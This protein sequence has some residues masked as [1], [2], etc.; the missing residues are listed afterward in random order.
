MKDW[1]PSLPFRES[2]SPGR[3]ALSSGSRKDLSCLDL[4]S[5]MS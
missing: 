3:S 4:L 2:F 1:L 5:Q